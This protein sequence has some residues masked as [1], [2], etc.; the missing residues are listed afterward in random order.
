V[1]IRIPDS[2]K[3]LFLIVRIA[4][5][6]TMAKLLPRRHD[7]RDF[8]SLDLPVTAHKDDIASMEHPIFTLSTVPDTRAQT[9]QSGGNTLKIIPS[10]IGRATVFDKDILIYCISQLVARKNRGLPIGPEVQLTA[11]DLMMATNRATNDLGY[12]RLEA[13]LQRLRGTTIQTDILT[14]GVSHTVGFGLLEMYDIVRRPAITG[15]MVGLKLKISDWLF[16]AIEGLEVLT[17]HEDYF[18]LRRPLERRLY[19]IARKHCGAQKQ[20]VVSLDLLFRKTGSAG[21]LIRFRFNLAKIAEGGHLPEY[22]YALGENDRVTVT[23]RANAKDSPAAL[24]LPLDAPPSRGVRHVEM[25]EDL[26]ARLREAAPGWDKYVLALRYQEFM[27]DK[28]T[29]RSVP[30][31]FLAWARKY[32][33]GKPPA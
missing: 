13:A 15:R 14:G 26:A 1:R 19:E 5:C 11:R 4:Y 31:S 24:E 9:Y 27:A 33:K 28:E 12:K 16:R 21:S 18:R 10:S 3:F 22:D 20:W 25:D 30:A 7:N 17:I 2:A 6:P 32:T 23:R 8:F 29:P